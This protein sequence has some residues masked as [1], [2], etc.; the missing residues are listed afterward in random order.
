[1]CWLRSGQQ[2]ANNSPFSNEIFYSHTILD[3]FDPKSQNVRQSKLL[4]FYLTFQTF[5]A[6]SLGFFLSLVLFVGNLRK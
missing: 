6:H 5:G 1:M 3:V 4:L 2:L